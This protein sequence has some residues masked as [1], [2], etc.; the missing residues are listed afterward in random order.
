VGLG[1]AGLGWVGSALLCSVL[2]LPCLPRHSDAALATLTGLGGR[3]AGRAN[4]LPG[5]R[6]AWRSGSLAA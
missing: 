4:L 5:V 6:M 2:A 1:W 3:D